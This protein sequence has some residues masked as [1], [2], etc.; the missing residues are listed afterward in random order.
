MSFPSL[1]APSDE[2]QDL[3]LPTFGTELDEE[4]AVYMRDSFMK[5][6]LV[7]GSPTMLWCI[8]GS[9]MAQVGGSLHLDPF[10]PRRPESRH[11]A[12]SRQPLCR[13]G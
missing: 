8:T 11:S 4:G 9:S 7:S 1:L 10:P 5:H 6:L 13:R 3:F 2:V 12:L